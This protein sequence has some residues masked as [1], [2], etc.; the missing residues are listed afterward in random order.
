MHYGGPGQKSC[1]S[2]GWA[3]RVRLTGRAVAQQPEDTA[4]FRAYKLF[5]LRLQRLVPVIVTMI[6]V[7]PGFLGPTPRCYATPLP[8][9]RPCGAHPGCCKTFGRDLRIGGGNAYANAR[10]Y[11]EY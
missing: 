10:L 1:N 11:F 7:T 5:R 8:V 2:Q 6:I 4:K 3:P 9:K